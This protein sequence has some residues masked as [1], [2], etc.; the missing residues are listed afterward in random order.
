VASGLVVCFCAA[1]WQRRDTTAP[2]AQRNK[3]LHFFLTF[4]DFP[5][6]CSENKCTDLAIQ[7][8]DLPE[9]EQTHETTAKTSVDNPHT[10]QK[11]SLTDSPEPP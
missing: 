1:C 3:K 8:T 10:L 2:D 7:A 6:K 11:N 5:H 9:P 4:P